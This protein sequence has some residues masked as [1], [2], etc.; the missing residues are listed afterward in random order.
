MFQI[1]PQTEI[2]HK[3]KSPTNGNRPQNRNR[4]QS[5]FLSFF[6]SFF[7]TKQHQATMV[8]AMEI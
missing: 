6:L 1:R 2:A 7:F 8:G 5:F 4:P 3:P